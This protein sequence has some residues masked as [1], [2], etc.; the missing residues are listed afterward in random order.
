MPMNAAYISEQFFPPVTETDPF[1]LRKHV[2]DFALYQHELRARDVRTYRRAELYDQGI[3]WLLRAQAGYDLANIYTQWVPI[4]WSDPND[5]NLIP[6]PVF[7]EGLKPR[8]NESARLARPEYRPVVRPRPSSNDLDAKLGAVKM[9]R[10]L[11]YRMKGMQWDRQEELLYYHLPVYGGAWLRSEWVMSWD[12]T[13]VI[14]QPTAVQCPGCGMRLAN[15]TMPRNQVA[16]LSDMASSMTPPMPPHPIPGVNAGSATETS[17]P[18]FTPIGP[19]AAT[20]PGATSGGASTDEEAGIFTRLRQA[21]LGNPKPQPQ[22]F[23]GNAF[24]QVDDKN[25]KAVACP[26]CPD[27]PPL[28]PAKLTMQEAANDKDLLGNPMGKTVPIGDWWAG[29][30]S[31]YDVFV[32]N[33][34]LNMRQGS[35]NEWVHIH[36]ESLDW[37][38][39][40]WP[41]QA[42]NVEPERPEKLAEFHPVAGAPDLYSG[43]HQGKLFKNSARVK[44][45][46]RDPGMYP[47]V[48]ES[49]KVIWKMDKGRH[50][51]MAGNVVLFNGELLLP[52]L[53]PNCDAVERVT[54]DYIPW[55][56]RDGG[57]R[58]Q[59]LSLWELFFEAQDGVNEVGSMKAAIRQR[60]AYPLYI[61]SR[62]HNLGNPN[63]RAGTP[64]IFME[65]DVDPIAPNLIPQLINNTTINPGAVDEQRGYVDYISRTSGQVE[66]EKG[67]TPPNV[68][69]AY[70]IQLLKESA[71]EGRAPRIRRIKSALKKV[72]SHGARL[73]AA[74]Y[75]EERDIHYKDDEMDDDIWTTTTAMDFKGQTD[76]EVDAEPDLDDEAERAE[77]VRDAVRLETLN[78]Q[79]SP[80][81]ARKINIILGLP[82]ELYED[83]DLQEDSAQREFH[84]FK[85]KGLPPVVD[86]SLDDDLTH[87][88]M[89]GRAALTP[90]FRSLALRANW[91]G[92]LQVL[93][94][95][96]DESLEALIAPPPPPPPMPQP[97]MMP[98]GMPPG[99]VPP[100]VPPQVPGG[101]GGPPQEMMG[102][103]TPPPPQTL[104]AKIAQMWTQKL[105][106]TPFFTTLTP[107]QKK[108]LAQV[109]MWRAHMEAHKL[110]GEQKQEA[111][112]SQIKLAAPGAAAT[113]A[114]TQPT[115][116]APPAQAP[117]AIQPQ[118]Q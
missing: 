82:K 88:K 39:L 23:A 40:R 42:A 77:R 73:M 48:D 84:T 29:I 4:Y 3:Q 63:R 16:R 7:N 61:I 32:K 53:M 75:I 78:P 101:N 38:A 69:A 24:Q 64:G 74:N 91:A 19:D 62:Q 17:G 67:T 110:H 59:G 98:P 114:G 109:V 108:A 92:A 8:L 55:E 33:L 70:A 93:G 103:P 35:I 116:T 95:D 47:Y 2:D 37:I 118:V 25:L 36:A 71:G 51:V 58:L 15:P 12:K 57:R 68:S 22:A 65:M 45:Y 66:V 96:W 26:L 72:W 87:Y 81:M 83:E 113:P 10:A 50:V 99:M 5:P 43:M 97:Q 117:L 107:D 86:P 56:I 102:P 112:Q 60:L 79:S 20:V 85:E 9:E 14:Q 46:I 104:Q 106:V 28:Q 89:H 34:G 30:L 1:K 44:E 94:A 27:H 13:T 76:V 52:P 100:G 80:D 11:R 21:L 49:G 54:L 41:E 31:P 6:T 105:T 111:A 90:W 18:S 115:T